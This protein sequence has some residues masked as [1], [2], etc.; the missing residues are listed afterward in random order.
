MDLCALQLKAFLDAAEDIDIDPETLM[1]LLQLLQERLEE[2]DES[3]AGPNIHDGNDL[4]AIDIDTLYELDISALYSMEEGNY[5][6]YIV[7]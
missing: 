1:E 7:L 4:S 2:Q 3:N 5:T 6:S